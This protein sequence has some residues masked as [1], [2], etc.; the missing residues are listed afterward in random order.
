MAEIDRRL[1]GIDYF[2]GQRLVIDEQRASPQL[3][4][5]AHTSANV[6]SSTMVV[7]SLDPRPSCGLD[8]KY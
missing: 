3:C 4:A 1:A 2:S 5:P 8:V 6:S 7:A